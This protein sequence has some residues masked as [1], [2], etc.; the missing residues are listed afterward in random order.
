MANVKIVLVGGGSITWTPGLVGKILAQRHL[1]GAHIVLHDIDEQALESTYRLSLMHKEKMGSACTFEQTTD[2]DRA[3]DGADYVLVAIS[4]GGLLSMRPDLEIPEKYGIYQTV[5]DTTGPGGL[6]RALRNVPVFDRLAKAMLR[7]CPDA[8]MLNLTNPLSA[9]TRTVNRNGIKALGLCHGILGVARSYAQFFGVP[10]S[11]LAYVNSGIDHCA[12]FTHMAVDG[13]DAREIL[14]ERGLDEWLC[15][16]PQEAEQDETFAPLARLR[17]GLMVARDLGVLPAI[18]D[19]HLTEFLPTFLQGDNVERYGLV[20]TTIADRQ[21]NYDRKRAE[22]QRVLSGETPLVVAEPTDVLGERQAD[23]VG[24]WIAALEGKT[25]VEDNLNAPN[26]GQIPQL[27]LGAIVETRGV[28]DG[29]GFHPLASPLPPQLEAIVRP[30][31]LRE[32]MTIDAA[33]EGDFDKA[34]AVLVTDPLLVRPDDARPMLEEM[35]AATR[36]W[37]PQFPA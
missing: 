4:T 3:L 35:I 6:S 20:R 33:L 32:E 25:L 1:D 16:P 7:H 12:W 15:L 10:M 14:A 36:A 22:I 26:I 24:S 21:A 17:V 23:D 27:P 34:L 19:R 18:G 31:A 5:G 11:Q 29:T 30:H 28:L 37:L 9:L 13:R 2:L 8:W